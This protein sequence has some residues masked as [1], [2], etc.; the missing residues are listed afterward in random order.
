MA[1]SAASFSV[2]IAIKIFRLLSSADKLQ[3]RPR[4]G[5]N[6]RSNNGQKMLIS[7]G[8][9]LFGNVS[10]F[11][12]MDYPIHIDT[13][14]SV[15]KFVLKGVVGQNFYKLMFFCSCRLFLSKQTAQPC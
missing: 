10:P 8:F 11:H 2:N 5:T 14:N 4:S 9:K 12:L 7:N 13:I 6:L 15:E 1:H 3:V